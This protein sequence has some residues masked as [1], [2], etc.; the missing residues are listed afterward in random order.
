LANNNEITDENILLVMFNKNSDRAFLSEILFIEITMKYV[1][2]VISNEIADGI[3]KNSIIN[4]KH[5]HF[6]TELP[7]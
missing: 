6:P 2:L 5:H 7:I 3:K 4:M 1:L